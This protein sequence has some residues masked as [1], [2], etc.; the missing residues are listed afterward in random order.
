[1]YARGR[2]GC[3]LEEEEV[4]EIRM[5]THFKRSEV[6]K[7]RRAFVYYTTRQLPPPVLDDKEG[8]GGEDKEGGDEDD[9]DAKSNGDRDGEDTDAIGNDKDDDKDKENGSS[10]A[11]DDA[12]STA[13]S[14]AK[15]PSQVAPQP[16]AR[17]DRDKQ[18]QTVIHFGTGLNESTG[19][20]PMEI[21]RHQ[22]MNI[23][24]ISMN[25]LGDRIALAFGFKEGDPYSAISFEDYM[26]HAADF[27]RPGNRDLKL[28]IAFKIQDFDGDEKLNKNDL[29]KYYDTIARNGNMAVPVPKK[30]RNEVI[31]KVLSEISS[32]PKKKFLSFDDFQRV[33]GTTD[34]DTTL[35]LELCIIG[36]DAKKLS[37]E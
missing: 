21:T 1:M 14:K 29:K 22:F 6:I 20:F 19:N 35:K 30:T 7:Y 28:K 5:N 24:S 23:K 4:E 2:T 10:K 17:T 37:T 32:D 8:E 15:K 34:F 18:R 27:N 11:D 3:D 9:V 33:I 16:P 13:T 31:Q 36:K 25:P 12:S 26:L